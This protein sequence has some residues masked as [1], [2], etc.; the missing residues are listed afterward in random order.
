M[1]WKVALV[2]AGACAALVVI[3]ARGFGSDPHE[4]PFMLK[5]K[6]APDF[7]LQKLREQDRIALSQLRGRPVI[8]NFWA[9][10]CGPCKLEHPVLDWGQRQYGDQVAFLGVVFEDTAENAEEFLRRSPPTYPQ[11]WDPL[12]QMAVDYGVAGVPE[13]YF[14]DGKG[15]IRSKYVGPIPPE[16]LSARVKDLLEAAAK[17]QG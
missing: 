9:T 8:I 7:S 2:A 4:V 12:S 3:L 14:I 1:R 15:I 17:V 6:P 10:W 13:T 5:G 11:L 16:E